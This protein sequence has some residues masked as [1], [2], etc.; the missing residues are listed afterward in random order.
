[1]KKKGKG[2]GKF[3]VEAKVI[4]KDTQGKNFYRSK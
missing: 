3:H 2:F 4:E 1:M